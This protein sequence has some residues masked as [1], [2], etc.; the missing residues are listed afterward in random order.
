MVNETH[1]LQNG[2][3]GI[4]VLEKSTNFLTRLSYLREG[5][6]IWGNTLNTLEGLIKSKGGKVAIVGGFIRDLYFI[7]DEFSPR[8]LD[9]VVDD[10]YVLELESQVNQ[11]CIGKTSLGGYRLVVNNCS[12]DIW[13]VQDTVS[14]AIENHL[15]PS[16]ANLPRL[17]FLNIES[18]VVELQEDKLVKI[19]DNGFSKAINSSILD[20]NYELNS[21][22]KRNIMKSLMHS[23]SLKMRIGKSLAK[24]IV[25]HSK[26]ISLI[27]LKEA[28]EKYYGLQS[29]K[30]F[31][32]ESSISKLQKALEQNNYLPVCVS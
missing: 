7:K 9:L 10:I 26:T 12:V 31:S 32:I 16:F 13:R 6:S 19:Y 3:G 1:G 15:F 8:D 30:E 18:I 11:L 29:L 24:Y 21:D 27:A 20:I 2:V 17:T 25:N 22:P 14:F 4:S 28:Q 23:K 5:N